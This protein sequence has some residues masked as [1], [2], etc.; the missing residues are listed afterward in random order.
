MAIVKRYRQPNGLRTWRQE[1]EELMNDMMSLSGGGIDREEVP[2]TWTPRADL[3][4]TEKAYELT[5]DLPGMEKK[6]ITVNMEGNRLTIS[7]ERTEKSEEKK[8][9]YL[10]RERIEGSFYRTFL[11]PEAVHESDVKAVFKEGVLRVTIPK[12]EA[13]KPK[14]VTV[15]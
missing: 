12:V 15:Q 9:G 6:D 11:M 1:I 8:K 14:T 4:E 10:R 13:K 5:V 7:G 2:A 3:T